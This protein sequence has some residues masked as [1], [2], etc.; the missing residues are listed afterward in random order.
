MTSIQKALQQIDRIDAEVLLMHVLQKPRSYL[1]AWPERELSHEQL[2]QFTALIQ[3]RLLGT[4]IAYLVGYKEF[5]SLSLNVTPDVLIPRPET[6]LLVE[7]ALQQLDAEKPLKIADIGTGSGAIAIALA[8]E[9]KNW[10]F[11]AIDISAKALSVAKQNAEK[12]KINNI[13]FVEGSYCEPLTEI[14]DAIVSNPPYIALSDPHLQQGDLR[15]EPINALSADEN[16]IA[17]LQIIAEQA[18]LHLRKDGLLILEHGYD[19][20]DVIAKVLKE[21]GYENVILHRDLS[22]NPRVTQAILS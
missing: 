13:Q 21:C 1:Y 4:P 9:R 16:G 17:A 14:M 8:S 18:R 20:A 19:Q 11:T 7:L 3:Q 12:F 2:Q 6:E 22:G 5:W 15:F 10:Q